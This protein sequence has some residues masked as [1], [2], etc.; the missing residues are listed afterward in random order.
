MSDYNFNWKK[1]NKHLEAKRKAELGT[2]LWLVRALHKV[3][4]SIAMI[5]QNKASREIFCDEERF[6]L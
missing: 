6:C 4:H 2:D 3:A 5:E 1:V